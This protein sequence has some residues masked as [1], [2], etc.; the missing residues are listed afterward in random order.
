MKRLIVDT[1]PFLRFLLN[2]VPHQKKE[3]EKLLNQAKKS[4]I[5]LLVPQIVIFEI[6]FALERYYQYPKEE[7]IIKLKSII[8]APYLEVADFQIFL[9]GLRL[10]SELNLSLVDCFLLTISEQQE[11]EL[12]T[13]DKNLQ[14]L[15]K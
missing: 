7:I 15:S 2:D 9:D 10:Y 13:F 5:T 12:F 8:E 14:R 3:F 4:Q 11:T 1:N 6:N